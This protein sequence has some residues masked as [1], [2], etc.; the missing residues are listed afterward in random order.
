MNPSATRLIGKGGRFLSLEVQIAPSLS[1]SDN[2]SSGQFPEYIFNN[3]TLFSPGVC[4]NGNWVKKC[5]VFY[6]LYIHEYTNDITQ[7]HE[8]VGYR[9]DI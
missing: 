9:R 1:L 5:P 3:A 4:I 8:D 6:M 2:S 7:C